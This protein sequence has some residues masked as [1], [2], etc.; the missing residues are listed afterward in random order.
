MIVEVFQVV[1]DVDADKN[2]SN[3]LDKNI[4]LNYWIYYKYY[5]KTSVYIQLTTIFSAIILIYKLKNK[6]KNNI[7][8]LSSLLIINFLYKNKL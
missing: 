6:M 5:M 4:N 3:S 8:D 2:I 7:A 1:I